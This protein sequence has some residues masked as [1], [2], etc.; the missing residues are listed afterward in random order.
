[1]KSQKESNIFNLW[2]VWV[3]IELPAYK[4]Y[5]DNFCIIFFAASHY[6]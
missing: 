2:G 3:E 6:V 1:V 5:W 4:A